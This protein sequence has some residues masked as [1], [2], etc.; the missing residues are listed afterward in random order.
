[1][2]NIRTFSLYGY[3]EKKVFYNIE[4]QLRGFQGSNYPKTCAPQV[5]AKNFGKN[6][7][8]ISGASS[9]QPTQN[10]KDFAQNLSRREVS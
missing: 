10:P 9:A 3:I 1:L 5:R 8:A 6:F 4:G 2:I 7:C